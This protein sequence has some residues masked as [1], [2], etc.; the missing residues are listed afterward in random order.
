MQ[1]QRKAKN[2]FITFYIKFFPFKQSNRKNKKLYETM[3]KSKFNNKCTQIKKNTSGITSIHYSFH[4]DRRRNIK[5]K[6]NKRREQM[7]TPL[8]AHHIT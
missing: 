5:T 4:H 6:K 1:G 3:V 7:Q 8:K 2:I